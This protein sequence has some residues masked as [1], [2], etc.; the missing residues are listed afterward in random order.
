GHLPP[1]EALPIS[2]AA[3]LKAIALDENGAEGHAS[4]GMTRLAYDWDFRTA[5]QELRRATELNPSYAHAHHIL[6][7]LLGILRRNDEALAEI[8]KA[9]EADPLSV[10]VRSILAERLVASGRCEEALAEDQKTIELNPSLVHVGYVHDR[11]AGCFKQR[12]MDKEAFEE[13]MLSKMAKGEKPED[14]ERYRKLYAKAGR[15]GYLEEQVKVMLALWNK[16]H[17]HCNAVDMAWLYENMG[18]LDKSYAWVDKAIEV[19]STS[20]FWIL[21]AQKP[22]R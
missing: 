12:G 14:I 1:K 6:A 11:K 20:L 3:A 22:F 10:P 8:R 18:D 21:G 19:R 15:K 4:L 16:D 7:I 2:Q 5:E 9:V 17:W 13:E